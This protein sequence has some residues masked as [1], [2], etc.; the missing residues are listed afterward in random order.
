MRRWIVTG[1]LVVLL[2]GVTILVV[3]EWNSVEYVTCVDYVDGIGSVETE[4]PP[5]A[6]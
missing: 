6:P 5:D 2:A 3:R 1:A 4:C